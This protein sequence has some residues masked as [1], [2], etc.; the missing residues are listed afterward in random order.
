MRVPS[1]NDTKVQGIWGVSADPGHVGALAG[2][3][4][5]RGFGEN[6]FAIGKLVAFRQSTE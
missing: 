6:G 1:S 2:V 5:G 3:Q 4:L